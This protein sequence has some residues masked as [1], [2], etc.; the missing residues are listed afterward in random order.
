MATLCAVILTAVAPHGASTAQDARC[1]VCIVDLPE[2]LERWQPVEAVVAVQAPVPDPYDVGAVEV[3]VR[4]SAPGGRVWHVPAFAVPDPERPFRVRLTLPEAGAWHMTP[5]LRRAGGAWMSGRSLHRTVADGP[6]R[7]FVRVDERS[8]AMLR[9]DDGTPFFPIGAN[10]AWHTH[11]ALQEFGRRFDALSAAG[12]TVARIWLAPWTFLPE[13]KETPL[14][15]YAAREERM[16]WFDEILRMAERRGIYLIVVLSES[17]MFDPAQRWPENPYNRVNGGP[18]DA[19]HEFLTD[20]AARAAYRAQ[21]RYIAARWGYSTQ[22]VAW[23]WMNEVNSAPGFETERLLP[24]LREMSAALTEYDPHRHLRTISYASIDGDPRVWALPEIELV[25]RHEY[26]QGDPKWFRPLGEPPVRFRQVTDQPVKPVLVGEFGASADMENAVGAYRQGI[27]LHNALWASTFSGMAGSAMYWWWDNYLEPG[28]LWWRHGGL[29]EYLRGEDLGA[30]TPGPA[31]VDRA[32]GPAVTAM[33]L[34]EAGAGACGRSLV[35]V[36]NTAW[37]H[38]AALAQWVIARSADRV[39][40]KNFRYAAPPARDVVVRVPTAATRMRVTAYDTESGRRMRA[41]DVDGTGQEVR[42]EEPVIERD[43]AF[44][45]D[46]VV[47]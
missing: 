2:R 42:W 30:M 6:G 14:G 31:K 10:I 18:C 44:K 20:P 46:C 29:A 35:W 13:W 1:S 43:I 38:D 15:N 25:Q 17:G 34:Q 47:Q 33:R 39:K 8:G 4:L 36:R 41:F 28:R 3:R 32:R 22:I 24:W 37:Q 5:Q 19:P 12:G 27:H 7:G 40:A 11:D 21:L 45:L 9:F 16:A 26:N 23:E